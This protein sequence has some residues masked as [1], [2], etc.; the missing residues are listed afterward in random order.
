MSVLATTL[1]SGTY[2]LVVRDGK[3]VALSEGGCNSVYMTMEQIAE[4]FPVSYFW[5]SRNWLVTLRLPVYKL[6]KKTNIFKREELYAAIERTRVLPGRPVGRA[7]KTIGVL[8]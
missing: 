5:V 2:R 7:K 3:I 8:S 1:Q 4:E 6:G